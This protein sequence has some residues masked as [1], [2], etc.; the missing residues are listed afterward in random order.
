MQ[1]RERK[2]TEKEKEKRK[3]GTVPLGFKSSQGR[4]SPT[5][6]RLPPP[7]RWQSARI[8]RVGPLAAARQQVIHRSRGWIRTTPK[9][10]LA[11]PS[12]C[13]PSP[14]PRPLRSSFGR[15]PVTAAT[16]LPATPHRVRKH[17]RARL[18]RLRRA[19]GAGE[20]RN[21]QI[22]AVFNLGRRRSPLLLRRLQ[23]S[24]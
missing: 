11:N 17:R 10:L 7:A 6:H 5:P 21:H 22:E 13:S 12:H 23:A 4:P 8:R 1:N 9:H 2:E 16:D 19:I 18:R 24:L 20:H 3:R 14:S 15:A